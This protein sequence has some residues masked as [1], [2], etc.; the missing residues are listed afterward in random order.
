MKKD[1]LDLDAFYKFVNINKSLKDNR[2]FIKTL[3]YMVWTFKEN[4]EKNPRTS[5]FDKFVPYSEMEDNY[6]KWAELKPFMKLEYKAT[7][8]VY[9][10]INYNTTEK[11]GLFIVKKGKIISFFPYIHMGADPVRPFLLN[12]PADKKY[13]EVFNKYVGVE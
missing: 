8:N 10:G 6:S 4:R 9:Y 1:T 7:D 2:D 11:L 13:I 5:G 12:K 3:S